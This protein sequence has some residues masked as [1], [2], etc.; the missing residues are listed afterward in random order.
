MATCMW[1]SQSGC[2]WCACSRPDI[3]F[4][5]KWSEAQAGGPLTT[6]L[7]GAQYCPEHH[8]QLFSSCR[9][10]PTLRPVNQLAVGT[11]SGQAGG[12]YLVRTQGLG[13]RHPRPPQHPGCCDS[14]ASAAACCCCSRACTS[15]PSIM[16]DTR[17]PG[18][19]CRQRQRE[20]KR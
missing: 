5:V 13:S 20:K 15:R 12:Q 8:S 11:R 18:S 6:G 19:T 10:R 2:M 17:P 9:V 3:S 4:P 16:A 14:T 7:T 1:C